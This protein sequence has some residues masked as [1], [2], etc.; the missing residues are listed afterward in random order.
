MDISNTQSNPYAG[1]SLRSGPTTP[2]PSMPGQP[3]VG[4]GI[5]QMGVG[6]LPHPGS[7]GTRSGTVD[8]TLGNTVSLR[9][10]PTKI[11]ETGTPGNLLV[12]NLW[13][14]VMS[15][16]DELAA[17]IIKQAANESRESLEAARNQADAAK[18]MLLGQAAAL[19]TEASQMLSGAVASLV[20]TV[21]ASAV[22]LHSARVQL[23]EISAV[24]KPDLDEVELTMGEKFK[25]VPNSDVK[26]KMTKEEQDLKLTDKK[27][28]L[29]NEYQT[30]MQRANSVV[31][32]LNMRWTA[33]SQLTQGIGNFI[34][35]Y[36][37]A[38]AKKTEATGSEFAANA[39]QLQSYSDESSK[40]ADDLR[41]LVDQI[42]AILKEIG[43]SKAQMMQSMT[44]V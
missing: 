6:G 3:Q 4:G 7:T 11:L 43:D 19:R 44:R 8:L 12:Q 10:V 27:N 9:D 42:V 16:I 2:T 5:G 36:Y 25:S 39:Q 35:T 22:S 24:K 20:M 18:A 23:K 34:N 28:K 26:V 38:E 32:A 1:V 37:Q 17:V 29:A 21:V 15:V 30:D 13:T 33:V 41:K 14:A 40:I 31:G